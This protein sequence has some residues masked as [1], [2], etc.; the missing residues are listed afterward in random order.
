MVG[1][2]HHS[3]SLSL[4]KCVGA[5]EHVFVLR[6][7]VTPLLK[8][9]PGHVR[10][11]KPCRGGLGRH[12]KKRLIVSKAIIRTRLHEEKL[13]NRVVLVH[14]RDDLIP[15]PQVVVIGLAPENLVSELAGL[16]ECLE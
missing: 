1:D 11:V 4:D 14:C 15:Q 7:F 9:F 3:V 2:R 10:R 5:Q 8:F 6:V 12:V 13:P 16:D